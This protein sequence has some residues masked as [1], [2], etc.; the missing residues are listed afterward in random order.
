MRE[1]SSRSAGKSAWLIP[2][3][4]LYGTSILVG[5]IVLAILPG[6]SLAERL[7]WLDSGICAQALTHTFI[8]GKE[9]LPLCARNTGIYLG[10]IITFA[11]FALMGR[12]RA[13]RIP[14]RAL[15]V[16]L[17]FGMLL[18]AVDGLNSFFLDLR[19]PHLYQPA[20]A[21]RLISG[22]ATGLAMAALLLPLHNRLLWCE[23]NEQASIPSW[24]MLGGLL[25]ALSL[26]A[27]MVLAQHVL[28]LYPLALLS[29][30]GLIAAMGHLNLIV[31]VAISK[32]DETFTQT[33]ELLPFYGL[34]I[35][36][37]IG[38]LALLAQVRYL[39]DASI[40]LYL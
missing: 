10:Y 27:L 11:T 17:I 36:C 9:L 18:C 12:A 26:C 37:A 2:G 34:A 32:R 15:T 21:F 16:V 29:T 38:E 39:L 23:Y 1:L 19:L 6:A 14:P 4:I 13:Q 5:L 31:I 24:R 3:A 35:V 20:N 30:T 25:L 22:L 33:R 7:R 8:A 28:L 40:G